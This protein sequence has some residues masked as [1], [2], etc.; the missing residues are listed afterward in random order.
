MTDMHEIREN[1]RRYAEG[2]AG[3]DLAS[4]PS[5]ELAVLTCMDARLDVHR[6]LGLDL[7]DAHVIRNAGGSLTDDATRSLLISSLLGTKEVLVIQHTDC[8]MRALTEDELRAEVVKRTGVAPPFELGAL[9]ELQQS[10]RQTVADIDQSP[11]LIFDSVKG[12]IYDVASGLI[13]EVAE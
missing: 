13:D 6:I 12:Y 4:S 9:P 5:K 1:N 11:L 10:V 2:F 7:G 3:G 8:R